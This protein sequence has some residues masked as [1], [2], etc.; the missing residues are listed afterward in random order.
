M[1]KVLISLNH[2]VRKLF[3][4]QSFYFLV[5]ISVLPDRDRPGAGLPQASL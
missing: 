4:L 3:L 1:D 2:T 5:M